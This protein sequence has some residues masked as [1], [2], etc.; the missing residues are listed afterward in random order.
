MVFGALT[1]SLHAGPLLE[2]SLLQQDV[3]GTR[4]SAGVG[5]CGAQLLL[6]LQRLVHQVAEESVVIEQPRG[7]VGEFLLSQGEEAS[8]QLHLKDTRRTTYISSRYVR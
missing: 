1:L 2:D 4:V 8:A 7:I 6:K 5:M 3:Q